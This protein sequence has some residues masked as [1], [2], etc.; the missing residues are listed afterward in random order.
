MNADFNNSVRKHGTLG[1]NSL[2]AWRL[3]IEA[4]AA[5]GRGNWASWLRVNTGQTD[6]VSWCTETLVISV[7]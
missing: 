5:V 4:K 3:L 6:A 2:P 7:G 1:D